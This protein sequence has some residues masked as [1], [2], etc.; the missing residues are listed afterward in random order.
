M[1]RSLEIGQLAAAL[2]KAQKALRPA[3]KD[4]TNTFFKSSYA[5]LEAV[6]EACRDALSDNDI[7]YSQMTDFDPDRIW[8]ET[9][10]FH[11]SGEWLSGRY[12]AK[13]TKDDPQ[14]LGS[15]VTYAK[16][17]G[18][19]GAVGIVA[20]AEDDDAN[21]ASGRDGAAPM[22]RAA[23]PAPLSSQ[24][25]PASQKEP[26]PPPPPVS[27]AVK[28]A[29]AVS[30][31]NKAMENMQNYID[32]KKFDEWAEANKDKIASIE[33]YDKGLHAAL[34]TAKHKTYDRLEH[35]ANSG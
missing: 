6:T 34:E 13:P 14:G 9:I 29:A 5:D 21:L 26:A 23:A 22:K 35:P 12:P 33:G 19:M 20:T 8:V 10:L 7:A 1:N 27:E 2:A 32:W 25:K 31:A 11:K 16:R 17:Y 18:L 3:V 24:S 4:V 28:K 15:A 30:W